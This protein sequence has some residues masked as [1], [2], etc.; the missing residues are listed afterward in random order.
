MRDKG[1][2]VSGRGFVLTL[3]VASLSCMLGTVFV[4]CFA[5]AE[6][7]A[8]EKGV[9][10]LRSQQRSDGMWGNDDRLAVRDTAEVLKTLEVVAAADSMVMAGI[11]A[12]V[13]HPSLS[14]D[15]QARRIEALGPK[16]PAAILARDFSALSV[17]QSYD[18]G[19]ATGPGFTASDALDT[20]LALRA[21]VGTEF[22]NQGA[23]LAGVNRL[24]A[25]QNPDGGVP[26]AAGEVSSSSV[27]A[28]VLVALAAISRVADVSPL[29]QS[30]TQYLLAQQLDDGGFPAFQLMV[31]SDPQTSALALVALMS[32]GAEMSTHFPALLT[33]S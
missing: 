26:L 13:A 22:L 33:S 31:A 4:P 29:V 27:S 14:V 20:A 12:L 15:L 28:E 17:A 2:G 6:P 18:G 3:R 19:W 10:W 9:V 30:S 32:A 5:L 7:T 25:L 23:L 16:L 11:G 24:A 1:T 21:L 8:I